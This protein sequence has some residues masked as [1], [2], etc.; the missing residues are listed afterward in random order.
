MISPVSQSNLQI[1]P[2]T[3][4][5]WPLSSWLYVTVDLYPW[6]ELARDNM[7]SSIYTRSRLTN[8]TESQGAHITRK[9]IRFKV[10]SARIVFVFNRV[11]LMNL[12]G[13]H[14]CHS[15]TLRPSRKAY[16]VTQKYINEWE[17]KKENEEKR[18]K[19]WKKEG[20]SNYSITRRGESNIWSMYVGCCSHDPLGL[21]LD[22]K[23]SKENLYMKS[24]PINS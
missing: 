20:D 6:M 10:L 13:R 23:L 8:D 18:R 11:V 2:W 5:I 24:A 21:E 3:F 16:I 9:S 4:K 17:I 12:W 19:N 22:I 7:L 14:C 15:H 1:R